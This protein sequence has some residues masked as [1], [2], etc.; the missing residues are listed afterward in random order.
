MD[1]LVVDLNNPP[2]DSADGIRMFLDWARAH[3][4]VCNP[5]HLKLANKYDI[6]HAGVLFV[7]MQKIEATFTL[8][9]I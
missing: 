9:W 5:Y 1:R 2:L 6:D 4:I 3:R 7:P 8:A